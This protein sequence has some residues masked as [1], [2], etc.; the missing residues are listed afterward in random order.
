VR[1]LILVKH[2]APQVIPT[3]PACTWYLSAARQWV[4]SS[5]LPMVP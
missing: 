1:E 5:S 4:M 3:L 2:A